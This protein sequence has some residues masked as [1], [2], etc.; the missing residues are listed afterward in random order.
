[1]ASLG[2]LVQRFFGTKGSKEEAKGRLQIVLAYDRL[3]LSSEQME[4][5]RKDIMV[6]ISRHIAIDGE[7]VQ[8]DFLQEY[9]AKVV[10]NAPVARSRVPRPAGGD[11]KVNDES[12]SSVG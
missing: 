12:K 8:V 5:L 7:R 9:P 3:G 2:T 1:M 4:A 11:A 6:T 10:I